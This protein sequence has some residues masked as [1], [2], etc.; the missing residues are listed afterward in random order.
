MSNKKPD[1]EKSEVN[2]NI[3]VPLEKRLAFNAW[4]YENGVTSSGM[5]KNFMDDCIMGVYLK[6]KG[7]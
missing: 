5:L 2:I 3:R 4:C 1:N 6:R 7:D